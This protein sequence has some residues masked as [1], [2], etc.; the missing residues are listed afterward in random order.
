MPEGGEPYIVQ[1]PHGPINLG[2]GAEGEE[3]AKQ[4]RR[5][6]AFETDPQLSDPGQNELYGGTL[7]GGNLPWEHMRQLIAGLFGGGQLPLGPVGEFYD[8]PSNYDPGLIGGQIPNIPTA[9]DTDTSTPVAQS[10]EASRAAQP[11]QSRTSTRETRQEAVA[12]PGQSNFDPAVDQMLGYD[13]A[14]DLRTP[15]SPALPT[16]GE[17]REV[18]NKGA[19]LA[20]V[21][22]TNE[23]IDTGWNLGIDDID[24][25]Y[26]QSLKGP[27]ESGLIMDERPPPYTQREWTV[28]RPSVTYGMGEPP[29]PQPDVK[30]E[31]LPPPV[32]RSMASLRGGPLA[33]VFRKDFSIYD[34]LGGRIDPERSG[35]TLTE[36][37]RGRAA[38]QDKFSP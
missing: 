32:G 5:A 7:P 15:H 19:N 30:V 26:E 16:N 2:T 23:N 36:L 37:Q 14:L 34:V 10:A 25:A 35:R 27:P 22:P 9:K 11:T 13:S 3:A 29:P 18:A 31:A 4:Y 17:G 24:A 38:N 33:D 21:I 12:Q 28:P 20:G 8:H 1:G 6:L